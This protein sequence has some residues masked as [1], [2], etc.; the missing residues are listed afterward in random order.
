MDGTPNNIIDQE[1]YTTHAQRLSGKS[2]E[3]VWSEMMDK[4]IATHEI[5]GIIREWQRHRI[6]SHCAIAA[7]QVTAGAVE[8]GNGQIKLWGKA[9]SD[10][11]GNKARSGGDFQKRSALTATFRQRSA[12]E[13]LGRPNAAEPPVEHLQI[14]ERASNFA[15]GSRIGVQ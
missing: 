13:F 9:L 14:A 12:D 1:C 3:L 10:F 15:L 5:E 11:S 4:E 2:L 6:A 7:V 8:N